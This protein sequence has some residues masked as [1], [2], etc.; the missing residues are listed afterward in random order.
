MVS[1]SMLA[2]VECSWIQ[3]MKEVKEHLIPAQHQPEC[4]D[5]G[6]NV[7]FY[8]RLVFEVFLLSCAARSTDSASQHSC[9][10]CLNGTCWSFL[11]RNSG[12]YIT[13]QEH[14]RT[15]NLT[16]KGFKQGGPHRHDSTG[17]KGVVGGTIK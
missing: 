1:A 2:V 6:G 17:G 3:G 12:R 4:S 7:T 11:C 5:M 8:K 13:L 15:G 9:E 14:S 10:N 16:R